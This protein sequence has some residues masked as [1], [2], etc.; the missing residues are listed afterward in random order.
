M[1]ATYLYYPAR[2]VFRILTSQETEKKGYKLVQWDEK[3]MSLVLRKNRFL[4]R[5]RFFELKIEP[6]AEN[7]TKVLVNQVYAEEAK[8]QLEKE[9]I[10][11]ILKIFWSPR[12]SNVRHTLLSLSCR[13]AEIHRDAD[14][15]SL[16]DGTMNRLVFGN[17]I[18]HGCHE[19]FCMLRS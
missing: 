7:I 17:I 6:T 4:L 5:R 13:S 11:D 12:L 10:V 3:G 2:K 14:S 19:A 16:F 18:L 9:V 1:E 8:T 15:F